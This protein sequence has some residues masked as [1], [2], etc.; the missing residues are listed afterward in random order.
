MEY[1]SFDLGASG[2]RLSRGVFD[3]ER[4]SLREA[5]AFPNRIVRLGDGL[6]W[7]FLH[8]HGQLALGLARAAA[9]RPF[10]SL[11][12]DGFNNDFSFVGPQGDLLFPVRSYRDPR[13]V[14]HENAVYGKISPRTLYGL[15]GNQIAPFNTL[16]QLAAMREEGQ[17]FLLDHAHRLLFLPD[18]LGYYIC[19][20]AYTE[21][22]LASE[23]QMLD[24]A[25][26]DWIDGVLRLFG[27]PRRLFAPL[28]MP[29]TPVGE[30]SGVYLKQHGLPPFGL[31]AVCGHDTASA[32]LAAPLAGDGAVISCGTWTIVGAENDAP[33][34]TDYGF[35]HNIAN[36]GSL[37]GH[38]R[39]SRNVM[40]LWLLQE[41]RADYA[42]MGLS[43]G[44]GETQALAREAEPFAFLLDPDDPSLFHPGNMAE[45]IARVCRGTAGKAPRTPSE[46]FRCVYESLALQYRW[47]LERLEHLLKR[48]F[49][50][51]S[52]VGGGSRD[53]LMAQFAANALAR[54]VAAGPAEASSVGNLLVQMLS[55]GEIADVRQGREVVARSLPAVEYLP[56]DAGPWDEQ[57]RRF[58]ELFHPSPQG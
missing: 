21:Y 34:I 9:D 45:K 48:R 55:R 10:C 52:L 12:I 43:L 38:H 51:V 39:I 47:A 7:D 11:G 17:A 32:F 8:I 31:T 33:V 54:P 20:E 6:Y 3:G 50:S 35:A 30:A 5:H 44:F 25:S 58:T 16:M 29:G 40:G 57:Y 53:A 23:T 2:G 42:S 56:R 1:L 37:P 19:G 22:T 14:R 49:G 24:W 41:L 27:I 36:E 13:T 15:T 18:L 46:H 28:V 26:R 4:L